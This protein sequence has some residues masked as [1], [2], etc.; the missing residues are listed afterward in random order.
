MKPRQILFAYQLLL[1][2]SDTG[3]GLLLIVAPALTLRLMHLHPADP[4]A[5]PYLAYIGAFV[6]SVGIACFYGA[7]LTARPHFAAR[8]E[9]VWLLT[10]I[11][12]ASVALFVFTSVFTGALESGWITV[13]L[14]DGAFAL[15]QLT[16]LAK[17]WL[18]KI[19]VAHPAP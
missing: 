4:A 13:A 7:W 2:A 9:V 15:I 12:R 8:L 19:E 5:L 18:P 17:H 14:S 16:G 11:T 3:T 6:L 1:G 10:A